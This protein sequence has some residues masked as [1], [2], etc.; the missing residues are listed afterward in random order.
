MKLQ[1]RKYLQENLKKCVAP[2]E[3]VS[4]YYELASRLYDQDRHKDAIPVYEQALELES[5]PNGKAYFLAQIGICHYFLGNDQQA[6]SYL[7]QAR[8]SFRPKLVDFSE[9]M[10]GQVHFYLGAIQSFQG[11]PRQA[12]KEQLTALT[13]IEK[14]D[15]EYRWLLH[16]AISRSYEELG[17]TERAIEHNQKALQVISGDD[18]NMTYLYESMGNNHYELGQFEEAIKAYEKILELDP[19]FE[20]RDEIYGRIGQCYQ[21]QT[22]Y[23]SALAAYTTMLE[24]KQLTGNKQSLAGL[25]C[26]IANCHF[27]IGEFTKALEQAKEALRMRSLDAEEKAHLRSLVAISLYELG[28]SEHA[29]EEGLKALTYSKRFQGMDQLLF[30]MAMA[31]HKL[32]NQR[33]FIRFR[34]WCGRS[35][36]ENPW[37]KLL[38][39]LA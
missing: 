1:E 32:G 4:V 18:P 37:N 36:P 34:S 20:R 23:R 14:L 21:N 27:H 33:E 13:F 19:R 3:K 10:C 17:L 8:R 7:Q 9:E 30:R 35:F 29:V 39:K 11:K 12:L 38:A 25:H 2:E 6:S 15:R 31:Y 16:N 28:S 24:V 5:S 26:E 22:N